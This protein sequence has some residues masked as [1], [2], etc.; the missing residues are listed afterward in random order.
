MPFERAAGAIIIRRE[1]NNTF[2]LLLKYHRSSN[3]ADIYWDLPKGHVEKGEKELDA[4]RREVLEETG[5]SDIEIIDGF[6]EW[7]KYSFRAEGKFITKVVTF[8][9]A[10]TTEEN[11]TIS[12]EHT[13]YAWLPYEKAL[14]TLTFDNAKGILIKAKDFLLTTGFTFQEQA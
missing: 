6:K 1:R 3:S 12:Y 14:A 13:G 7:I 9:L 2:F 11:I 8:F 5:L 4:A 10:I